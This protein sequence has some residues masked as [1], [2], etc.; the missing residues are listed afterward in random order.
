[1]VLEGYPALPLWEEFKLAL[2]QD[3]IIS[4]RS[5][6]R[7]I[8]CTLKAISDNVHDGGRSLSHF[9]LPEPLFHSLEVVTEQEQ[10]APR[11]DVLLLQ[12]HTQFRQ[13]NEEQQSIFT[14][15]VLSATSYSQLGHICERPFFLEGK[16]GRGKTF[17]VD[18]MC[19]QLRGQN[20]IVLIVGSSALAATLYEGG[21]TAHN[22]F[23][24]PVLKVSP[25]SPFTVCHS[26]LSEHF[27]Q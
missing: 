3:F 10:Y 17:V 26:S 25:H 8:D 13:M 27:I 19:S 18:A 4:T 20:V 2:A 22:L 24:I 5:Q 12:A 11:S 1:M 15:V 21:R 23:Q 16:P 9:G 6:E 14:N 7:S